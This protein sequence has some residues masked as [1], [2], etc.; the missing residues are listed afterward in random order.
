QLILRSGRRRGNVNVTIGMAIDEDAPRRTRDGR[1]AGFN[2][3]LDTEDR[4]GNGVLDEGTEDTGLDTIYGADSL[5]APG[6]GDDGNDDYDYAANQQGTEG[7]NRLDSEDIDRG[8]FSRYNHYHECTIPLA[9]DMHRTPLF[10]GWQRYRLTLRDSSIF[11]KVGNPK[12]EDIRVVRVW[13]DGFDEH[14][15][16]DVYSLEFTGSK[17]RDPRT[18]D[19]ET[20]FPPSADS[21]DSSR[22]SPGPAPADTG[23]RVWVAQISRTTDTNYVPPFDLKR[24]VLGRTE[25]EASLLFGYSDLGSM[26]QA[27]VAKALA[28]PEDYRDYRGLRIYVHDDGNGLDFL[29]RLGTDSLNY[30]QFRAPVSSGT[31]VPGRDGKWY[32]FSLDLDSFPVLKARRDSASGG[33][34]TAFSVVGTPSL[35]DVRHTALGI[36]NR[37]PHRVTGAVWFDDIRLVGP[38]REPGYGVNLRAGL[39]LSDLGSVAVS[40]SYSDPNFRRFS[41]GR[42]VKTG[43]YANNLSA[44]ARMNLDRLLP[45]SWG[46]SIPLVYSWSQQTV[47]PKFSTLHPDL[48]L[49]AAPGDSEVGV[50]RSQDLALEGVRKQR[51][52]SR[53]LNYTLEALDFSW[54]RRAGASRGLLVR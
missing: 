17:W 44:S 5:W 4:N 36:V 15:T 6:S 20:R 21:S 2:G 23:E 33:Q 32:E 13:L 28:T 51:S 45:G 34:P 26:R 10:N 14:D 12:W 52:G 49:Q 27:R 53:L 1:I 22:P 24:D 18:Y 25:T 46:M 35:A 8:G 43:G 29:L 30:Y 48:R 16:L 7:N 40:Y 42:G 37:N 38:R 41:E 9:G 47:L 39:T 19:L 50:G 31:L 3:R 11:R 54:R